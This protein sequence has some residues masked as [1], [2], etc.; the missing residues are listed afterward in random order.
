M[1]KFTIKLADSCLNLG[2][3]YN[4][5]QPFPFLARIR[6][7]KGT[8]W[9]AFLINDP[10]KGTELVE[11]KDAGVAIFRTP[12]LQEGRYSFEIYSPFSNRPLIQQDN[13]LLGPGGCTFKFSL[14]G[15]SI[16][17]DDPRLQANTVAMD[18][19]ADAPYCLRKKRDGTFPDLPVLVMIKDVPDGGI[20]IK[21]VELR[22]RKAGTTPFPAGMVRNLQDLPLE[23]KLTPLVAPSD[24]GLGE[25][26]WFFILYIDANSLYRASS[27]FLSPASVSGYSTVGILEFDVKIS[28]EGR[29]WINYST[30]T[31]L[32]TMFLEELPRLDDWYYGDT[33]YHSIYTDNPAEFGGPLLATSEMARVVGLEWLFLT[34]HSWDF[35]REKNLHTLQPEDKW[36]KFLEWV[37]KI[38]AQQTSDAPLIIPAE[39]ITIR[40]IMGDAPDAGGEPQ[41]NFSLPNGLALHMLSFES[42]PDGLVQDAY[43]VGEFS[44]SATLEKLRA[45]TTSSQAKPLIFP[46]H[47][48][49]SGY[50][51]DKDECTRV[52]K[53]PF[54]G[55]L[56]VFNERIALERDIFASDLSNYDLSPENCTP[57]DPHEELRRGLVL[58][59]DEF[60]LPAV[61]EY[62]RE[63]KV[64]IPCAIIGGSDA[65]MDFNFALRPNPIYVNLKFTDNAFGK[66]RTLAYIPGFKTAFTYAER[67]NLLV[68]ALRLGRC[69]VTDGPVVIPTLVVTH[70]DGSENRLTCGLCEEKEKRFYTVQEGDRFSLEYALQIPGE[71]LGQK[72]ELRLFMPQNTGEA[73]CCVHT[74]L[75]TTQIGGKVIQGS[76]PLDDTVQ[77]ARSYLKALYFR[78]ECT[79]I[80][81][82]GRNIGYCC[83]N[84]IWILLE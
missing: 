58:W 49:S 3:F 7:Q 11:D 10:K 65:H 21:N 84:P 26:P 80:G 37:P 34:D 76:I 69:V 14:P 12:E 33:H 60:L 1:P 71:S 70:Q 51:W 18:V 56:Q 48:V 32:R 2:A 83:T 19:L 63:K 75:D 8:Q 6:P 22:C 23:K 15:S 59:R 66:V 61:K 13:L 79:S 54:F 67:K 72:A 40:T 52:K 28:Y 78:I 17:T 55:G 27:T 77:N 5:E 38:V 31:V 74:T 53:S 47:P 45:A 25:T 9:T 50:P 81:E 4:L 62:S 24:S 46:A 39:E 44:L 16:D 42:G 29:L 43:F 57:K 35:T 41:P 73:E 36:T 20:T 30:T 64:I 82:N 68:T